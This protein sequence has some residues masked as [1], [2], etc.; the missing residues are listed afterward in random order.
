MNNGMQYK[1]ATQQ[2]MSKVLQLV[3][4]KISNHF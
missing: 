2:V 1:C 3:T 4:K